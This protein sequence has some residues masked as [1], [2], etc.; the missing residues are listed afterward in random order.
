M[1]HALARRFKVDVATDGVNFVPINGMTDFNPQE[2]PTLQAADDYDSNGF[3][4]FEKT[5][6]GAKLV[7]K[8]SRKL[9]TGG[10]FDP[11]QELCRTTQF[12]F[13]TAARVT[14]RWYD[15][16][17]A[18][19]AFS[20]TALVDYQQSKTGVADIEEVTITFTIDGVVTS[21]TNPASSPAV[22]SIVS[23]LPSGAAAGAQ[24]TIT[25]AYFTGASAVKF[26][27]VAATVYTIVSD[28]TIVAVMPTGTA[29]SAP[30]TIT[31]GAGTSASFA[32]T[33]S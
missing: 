3:A 33:R 2:T 21:I 8:A 32:Y 25:G 4:S 18:A 7:I 29:G 28:S 22:P 26:G 30:I 11:G 6:T 23:A 10:A 9:T 14:V 31:N 27:G 20:A 13:G 17:G 24:V 19:Q 12:Q 5:M 16:N 15:R 1:T